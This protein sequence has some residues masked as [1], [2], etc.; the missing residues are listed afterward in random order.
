[1]SANSEPTIEV[2]LGRGAILPAGVV[3]VIGLLI[4]TVVK[5]KSGLYG[6]LLAQS[7]FVIY[8][9][10]HFLIVKLSEKMN[11]TIVM[12]VAMF[13]F[14]IKIIVLGAIF[15]LA[16]SNTSASS[17]SRGAFGSTSIAIAIAWIVGEFFAYMKLQTH[18]PLPTSKDK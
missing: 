14:L 13:S 3:G 18:L 2:K 1:M 10:M 5:G 7:V 6:G 16:L 9:L 12:A 11:S 17:L 8:L 4:S 15:F